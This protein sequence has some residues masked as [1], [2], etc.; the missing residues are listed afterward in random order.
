RGLEEQEVL[1]GPAQTAVRVA[2]GGELRGARAGA[3][4]RVRQTES[5][6][7]LVGGEV[8]HLRPAWAFLSLSAAAALAGG[9]LPVTPSAARSSPPRLARLCLSAS[10]RSMTWARWVSGA[11]AVIS[12]PSILEV[13]IS[14][15]RLR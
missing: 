10:M 3:D 12:L 2:G 9:F 14:S 15:T 11:A 8:G 6:R 4:L 5:L 7:H 13:A 1:E